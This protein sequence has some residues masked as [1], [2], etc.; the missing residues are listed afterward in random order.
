MLRSEETSGI[1]P[2][3]GSG[4]SLTDVGERVVRGLIGG[5]RISLGDL[6]LSREEYMEVVWP[7]LPA[8]NPDL[9]VPIE[10]VWA[11]IETRDRSALIRLAPQFEGLPTELEDVACRGD[12]QEFETFR[13]HTD[14]WVTLRTPSGEQ[15]IQLFK[16]VVERG[17]GYKLF[18][19]YDNVL[20]AVEAG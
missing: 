10:Y 16:D 6:R 17:A 2:F 8:S 7:E 14:C 4:S 18:R 1:A 3:P 13:V 20:R 5:D 12:V 9:N 19:Y 15:R 11:D